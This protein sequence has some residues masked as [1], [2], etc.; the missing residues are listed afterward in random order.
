MALSETVS[1]TIAEPLAV[2]PEQLEPQGRPRRTAARRMAVR[3]IVCLV[4]FALVAVWTADNWRLVASGIG[5]LGGAHP[6]WLVMGGVVTGLCWVAASC[7]RQGT[8]VERLPPGRLLAVQFAAGAA[9]HLLPAGLGAHAVTLRFLRGCGIPLDRST[10]ALALYSLVEAIVRVGLL[11]GL[12]LAFPGALRLHELVPPGRALLTAG[13][14]ACALAT[15]ATTVLFAAR[16]LRR[17][18]A[19]FLRTA[20]TDARLLHKMPARTV[21][22][23]GGAL[24]FPLLQAGVL[25]C[26]ASAL[27]LPV[28]WAYIVIA[29][30]A[31]SMAAG[32]IP[33]PGGIGSIEPVLAVALV[34]VGAPFVVATATVI[35]FR[36]LTVWL[37]LLPG[38]AMLAMLVR[39][40]IL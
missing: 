24:A 3:R 1:Q 10:A 38:V 25:V 40:R 33:A 2:R 5:R 37:P 26:V 12:V 35:G 6:G 11:V 16:R 18:A 21:A 17:I 15:V 9:N 20:L 14:V 39:R 32:M 27:E 23:W 30:L 8:I 22:L 34:M 7:K 13:I 31:A 29:Y 28:P 4:P 36:F 19:G